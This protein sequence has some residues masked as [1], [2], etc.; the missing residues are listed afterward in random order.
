MTNCRLCKRVVSSTPARRCRRS[1]QH[2]SDPT[3]RIAFSAMAT[4]CAL[5]ELLTLVLSRHR[6]RCGGIGNDDIDVHGEQAGVWRVVKTFGHLSR[7]HTVCLLP[8]A[9]PQLNLRREW[10]TRHDPRGV[11]SVVARSC[12]RRKRSRD[13]GTGCIEQQPVTHIEP[14]SSCYCS[15]VGPAHRGAGLRTS[16]HIQESPNLNHAPGFEL[17]V[18]WGERRSSRGV[19]CP[20]PGSTRALTG[21]SVP[22]TDGQRRSLTL[23]GYYAVLL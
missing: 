23:A 22:F 12:H 21:T 15:G 9:Q 19:R 10:C 20:A 14:M 8:G 17:L 11:T 7:G 6:K 5:P 3:T 16:T 2:T 1:S 4:S 13:I 18:G